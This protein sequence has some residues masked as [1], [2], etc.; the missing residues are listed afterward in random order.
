MLQPA[1]LPLCRAELDRSGWDAIDVLFVT[2]DAYVDHP[3]FG[4]ALLGRWLVD[5]GFRV[6]IVA[7]PRWDRLDD[8][9]ALGRPRLFAGVTAGALDSQLA[10]YTAFR[11]RR[12][13][14]AYTPGGRT[15]AR[16]NR[17]CVVYA[18]LVRRAF[19]GLPIVLGGIEASLRRVAHYDFWKDSLR[20]SILL[21]SKADAVLYGMAE[22]SVLALARLLRRT[23]DLLP[24]NTPVARPSAA[25]YATIPGVAFAGSLTDVPDGATVFTLPGYEDILAEPAALIRATRLM[26]RQIQ[27]GEAWAVQPCGERA[28]LLT[29]PGP[30][31]DQDELDR[32]YALPYARAAHPA[33]TKPIPAL[34]M[35]H[36]SITTHRGCGGGCSFCTLALHQGRR[37]R[38]R[39]AS[40]ILDE[41]RTLSRQ[42]GFSGSLSDVGG[43]SANMWNGRCT[44]E[45]TE[46]KRSSCLT[47]R[48]CPH[49]QVDQQAILALLRDIARAPGVRH[50]RVASGLRFDLAMSD[51]AF[52]TGLI[53]DFVGGQ[54]KV[55]PEHSSE[56]VL[57]LMR[58]PLFAVFESFLR[59]FTRLSAMAGKQ[60]YLVPYL[61]SAFPG[62]TQADMDAL[63]AWFRERGW[64]PRQAQCFIPLPGTMAAAMFYARADESGRPLYVARSDAERLKQHYTLV[65]ANDDLAAPG[66]RPPGLRTNTAPSPGQ[67]NRH[68][69]TGPGMRPERKP[70][71][72][73]KGRTRRP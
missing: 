31:L 24:D 47:P 53:Q 69:G 60:Q 71:R 6:G 17:A 10:H 72:N 18:N 39:S 48:P 15:G 56:R 46:C 30:G 36:T 28:V 26:E 65:P 38:S 19:P 14:D 45:T 59:E 12:S 21:D 13:D 66:P 29:P 9:L 63:A 49:F 2:G 58:K 73:R 54:L 41:V 37:I 32:L 20:R 34:E 51:P 68:N 43:P 44:A 1:F 70:P 42:T 64:Q 61:M 40:S 33:Y 25:A 4:V 62:C 3:A 11:K 55:A 8:I 52:L 57:R 22:A 5:H 23:A 7:Q 50:V 27:H 35:L 16:P 67:A